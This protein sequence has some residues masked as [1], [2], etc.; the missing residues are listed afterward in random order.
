MTALVWT[1]GSVLPAASVLAVLRRMFA[2]VLVSGLSMEPTFHAGDRLLVRRAGLSRVR[3]GDV[4]VLRTPPWLRGGPVPASPEGDWMVKRAAALPGD[5]LPESVAR[6]VPWD[7]VGSGT[8]VVLG[9]NTATSFDSRQCGPVPGDGLLGIVL[10]R[11][12]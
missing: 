2:V 5:P 4:I 6:T 7:R 10:R 12:G 9:D 3:A 11:I 8:V 1:A